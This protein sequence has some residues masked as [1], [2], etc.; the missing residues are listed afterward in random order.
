MQSKSLFLI[1]VLPA[2]KWSLPSG[3]GWLVS[4]AAEVS[5]LIETA[6]QI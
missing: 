6:L 2:L 1:L 5:L 3:F 4:V